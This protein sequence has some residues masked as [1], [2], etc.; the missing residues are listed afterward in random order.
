[1]GIWDRSRRWRCHRCG[2]EG[3]TPDLVSWRLVGGPL[4]DRPPELRERVEDWFTGL[5]PPRRA[6][7]PSSREP[8][9]TDTTGETVP[10]CPDPGG[11]AQGEVLLGPVGGLSWR[12]PEQ[13][14]LRL[15]AEGPERP[16]REELLAFWEA[17]GRVDRDPAVGSWLRRRYAAEE[18][19]PVEIIARLEL[20]RVLPPRGPWPD[21]W[22]GGWRRWP[23]LLPL[24]D[25]RGD[26]VSVQGRRITSGEPRSL[27]PRGYQVQG[28]FFAN[29]A[30]RGLLSGGEL[31]DLL[32]IVEGST[33]FLRA[34]I[35]AEKSPKNI[36]VLGGFS[37]SW[38]SLGFVEISWKLPI[39]VATDCYDPDG[40]GDRYAEAIA[41]SLPGRELRRLPLGLN[42]MG[43]KS[44]KSFDFDDCVRTLGQLEDYLSRS[45]VI[46]FNNEWEPSTSTPDPLDF[47]A[48]TLN[49]LYGVDELDRDRQ[50]TLMSL[51]TLPAWPGAAR[52]RTGG[53]VYGHGWGDHLDRLLGGGI[54]PGYMLALGAS[55]AGAGK[56][57]WLMQIV[58]GLALRSAELVESGRP[59]PLTPI[60]VLSEMSPSALTWRTLARWTGADSRI[61]R[62]GASAERLLDRSDAGELV[63]RTFEAAREALGGPLRGSRRWIR[64]LRPRGSGAA[65]LEEAGR[66]LERWREQLGRETGRPIWPVLVLDPV[67]RWQDP[68]KGEVEALNA[69][70]E[71]L[72]EMA[73]RKGKEW[74]VLLT[75]DTNK[76]T[77]SGQTSGGVLQEAVGGF[78]GSYKLMHLVD[79]ALYLHRTADRAPDARALVLET[80]PVKNRWG[81][82][83]G[84]WPHFQWSP[85]NGRF[86]PWTE[87]EADPETRAGGAEE[88]E[89]RL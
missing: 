12:R 59:G 8:H 88:E 38:V 2:V 82:T 78:R 45:Y 55:A 74:I 39:Y 37:G 84:P 67:Q 44:L 60:L 19:D 9:H 49:S 86:E 13:S 4:R 22:S 52:R 1:M 31:P 7:A 58:D 23:L 26:F 64:M 15:V 29:G 53:P 77:A 20:A 46:M 72:A 69:L 21:W 5:C 34:S 18:Y 24:Y 65:L 76:G 36:A 17:S 25:F 43:D 14:P 66:I 32:L 79:A 89:E 33:D 73:Q 40:T 41:R 16:P 68:S 42:K 56:T 71:G 47:H 80:V 54:H 75:S 83:R 70:V 50:R 35:L 85:W 30:G 63:E 10:H 28:S 51:A 61:F 62:A 3:D 11:G 6:P 48:P 87:A 57:A 81:S 27:S